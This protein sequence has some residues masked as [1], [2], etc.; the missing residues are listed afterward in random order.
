M[1]Y[2]QQTGSELLAELKETLYEQP[3]TVGQ[4]FL[5]YMIDLFF[6]YVII[7]ALSAIAGMVLGSII[8]ENETLFGMSLLLQY[9]LIY[10]VLVATYTFFE[11]ITKGRTIGKMV[12]KTRAVRSDGT[13]LT[14]NDALMRSLVRIIPFEPLSAFGGHPWH[15]NWTNTKVIKDNN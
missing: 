3:A 4:R 6:F 1:E 12:T 7:I 14:F 8:A 5:N 9:L 2:P 15:D 10:T 11:T 13:P